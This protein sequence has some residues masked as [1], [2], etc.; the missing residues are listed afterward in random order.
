[1]RVVLPVIV[2]VAVGCGGSVAG[3]DT[4]DAAAE[5][6]PLD[7]GVVVDADACPAPGGFCLLKLR[8]DPGTRLLVIDT[9]TTPPTPATQTYRAWTDDS[10]APEVTDA[11]KMS[12]DDP[13]AGT[14]EGN[15][16]TTASSLPHELWGMT[17]R[18]NAEID[19][20]CSNKECGIADLL[21]TQYRKSGPLTDFLFSVPYLSP[22]TP[23]GA[24][25]RVGALHAAPMDIGFTISNPTDPPNPKSPFGEPL[26]GA[27][28]VHLRAMSE[29]DATK[30]CAPNAA[31]DTNGDGV[32]DTFVAVDGS[33]SVCFEV[34]AKN[35]TV[36]P[37]GSTQIYAALVDVV[38][39]TG[40]MVDRRLVVLMTPAGTLP[41]K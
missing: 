33:A 3:D 27:A 11:L 1:M 23:D 37:T 32:D 26:D 24:V 5:T 12:V 40:A 4:H 35:E 9:A 8:L 30:G 18:V 14:F 31:K 21:V 16:F 15:V 36:L 39:A 34:T 22:A 7:V 25:L 13:R 29:G 2:I 17:V 38:G 20:V 6:S 10:G 19:A 28:L 41:A